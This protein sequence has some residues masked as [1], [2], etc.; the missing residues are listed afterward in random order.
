MSVPNKYRINVARRDGVN[1]KDEPMYKW[2]CT[3]EAGNWIGHA[4][5]VAE[6]ARDLFPAPEF[7]L[8]MMQDYSYTQTVQKFGEHDD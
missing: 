6:A 5:K 3:I 4:T 2:F 7:Q 1:Y 8:T